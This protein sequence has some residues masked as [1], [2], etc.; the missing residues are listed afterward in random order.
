MFPFNCQCVSFGSF[1]SIA[2]SHHVLPVTFINLAPVC[3]FVRSPH[4]S[5]LVFKP[6]FMCINGITCLKCVITWCLILYTVAANSH[7]CIIV[8]LFVH[9][10][11]QLP[12][13]ILWFF[14]TH[15]LVTSCFTCHLYISCNSCTCL[16][17]CKVTSFFIIAI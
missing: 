12:V 14:S 15:S 11:F 6:N 17:L 9:T 2:L 10:S 13:C 7:L 8:T 16:S 3:L 4:F 5:S 1:Q